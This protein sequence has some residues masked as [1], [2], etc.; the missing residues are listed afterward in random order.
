MRELE[1]TQGARVILD[2]NGIF[3]FDEYLTDLEARYEAIGAPYTSEWLLVETASGHQVRQR[4]IT[5]ATS[6][7]SSPKS[8]R[9]KFGCIPISCPLFCNSEMVGES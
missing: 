2:E 1:E 3:K 5:V 8:I 4:S 7:S 9:L 6:E